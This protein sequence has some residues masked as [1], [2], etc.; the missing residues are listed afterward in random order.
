MSGALDPI[1]EDLPFELPSPPPGTKTPPSGEAGQGPP[2]GSPAPGDSPAWKAAQP[3]VYTPPSLYEQFWKRLRAL[4]WARWRAHAAP[5]LKS[6]AEQLGTVARVA[7]TRGGAAAKVAVTRGGTAAK[8]AMTRGGTVARVAVKRGAPYTVRLAKAT[9]RISL[10]RAFPLL[11]ARTIHLFGYPAVVL[12]TA[13]Q[14]SVAHRAGLAID[15]VSYFRIDDPAGYTVYEAPPR[16]GTAI[17][18]TYL[19]TLLLAVLAVLC[20]AP[21]LTPRIVLDLPVSWVTWVQIWL[22]LAF[23]AHALPSYEEA[24]PVAEQARVGVVKADPVAVF[25][26]IPAQIVAVLTRFGGI[27]P[28]VAGGL[29]CWWLA[30]A[31]FH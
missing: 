29:A 8:V 1:Q 31:I 9:A 20:L 18:I 27:L 22:G 13:I 17:A 15:E 28:A 5:V 16:L 12:R 14:F 25:W 19:P 24:G 2:T 21:A 23:A 10:I 11:I 3:S 30:G 6:S 26:V 7:V 4:P